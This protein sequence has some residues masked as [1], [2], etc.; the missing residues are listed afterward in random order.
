MDDKNNITGII[1]AG[2]KSS[3]MGSDKAM[4]TFRGKKLFEYPYRLMKKLCN[5]I[6]RTGNRS[7][8]KHYFSENPVI[9][10]INNTF[11]NF[12]NSSYKKVFINTISQSHP[13]LCFLQERQAH[14][15][16]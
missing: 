3:R 6:N 10:N 15:A 7:F 4:L 16:F 11:S 14:Q 13:Y 12:D 9:V 8:K 2:G 1:L 5:A